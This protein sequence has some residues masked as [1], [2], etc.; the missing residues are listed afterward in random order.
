M[1]RLSPAALVFLAWTLLIWGTRIGNIWRGD[2]GGTGTRL[3]DTALA[4]SFVVLVL[5]VAVAAVRAVSPTTVYRVVVILAGWTAGVWIVRTVDILAD[6]WSVGFKVVHT[7]LAV[8]SLVL[9]ALAVRSP[10]ALGR[11]T[12]PAWLEPSQRDRPAIP[13]DPP[14]ATGDAPM[15]SG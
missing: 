4:A 2:D 3:A 5:A 10:R 12:G 8:V 6:D 14:T 7:A 1:R 11:S 9:A 13:V 15:R